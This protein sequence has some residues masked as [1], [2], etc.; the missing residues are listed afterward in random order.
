M[1]Y[2][3]SEVKAN[4]NLSETDKPLSFKAIYNIC[5]DSENFEDFIGQF[6]TY[7]LPQTLANYSLLVNIWKNN[8]V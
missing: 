4:Y 1:Q 5:R 8:M 2:D 7:K 6:E 3:V